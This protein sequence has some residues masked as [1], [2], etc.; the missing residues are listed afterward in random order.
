MSEPQVTPTT[1]E[2]RA[3]AEA[4]RRAAEEQ[5]Q[6]RRVEQQAT[7]LRALETDVMTLTMRTAAEGG[8]EWGTIADALERITAAARALAGGKK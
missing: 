6:Q 1:K 5:A 4:E 8:L 7:R 3:A 2:E